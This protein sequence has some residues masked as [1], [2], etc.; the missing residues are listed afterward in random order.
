MLNW[1]TSELLAA[2]PRVGFSR[3]LD[4]KYARV[5]DSIDVGGEKGQV[6]KMLLS[7]ILVK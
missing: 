7:F 2:W 1:F 4:M 5:G 3:T 6:A